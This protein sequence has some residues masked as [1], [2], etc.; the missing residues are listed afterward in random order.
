[1]VEG[2]P[3]GCSCPCS[4]N[5][6]SHRFL[7]LLQLNVAH[8]SSGGDDQFV[9]GKSVP[10]CCLQCLGSQAGLYDL[11]ASEK[12]DAWKTISEQDAAASAGRRMLL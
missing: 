2:G 3:A 11:G 6:N 12:S 7:C 8:L 10:C 9:I 4:S 1:M 5:C